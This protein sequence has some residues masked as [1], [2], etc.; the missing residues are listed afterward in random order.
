MKG[1]EKFEPKTQVY[2]RYTRLELQFIS[3]SPF[4][5]T[6]IAHKKWSNKM[7]WGTKRICWFSY[8]H[9]CGATRRMGIL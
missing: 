2:K 3:V 5:K 4:R 9:H 8:I 1:L 6:Y 7:V